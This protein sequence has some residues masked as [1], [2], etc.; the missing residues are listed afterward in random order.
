MFCESCEVGLFAQLEYHLVSRLTRSRM[1]A[2]HFL[3]GERRSMIEL[4]ALAEHSVAKPVVFQNL[5]G[6]KSIQNFYL[7]D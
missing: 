7:L 1:D 3:A 4:T 6:D 2:T 5:A